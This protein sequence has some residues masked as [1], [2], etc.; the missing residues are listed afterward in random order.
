MTD[1]LDPPT[2]I[3]LGPSKLSPITFTAIH[4]GF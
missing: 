2:E 3:A 1:F 4:T